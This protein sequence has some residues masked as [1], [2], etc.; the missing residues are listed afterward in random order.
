MGSYILNLTASPGD[1]YVFA[2]RR[3][4]TAVDGHRYLTT[5]VGVGGS[6]I[7]KVPK[8]PDTDI[9]FAYRFAEYADPSQKI[10]VHPR[11]VNGQNRVTVELNPYGVSIFGYKENIPQEMTEPYFSSP[12]VW[13]NVL[14]G[15]NCCGCGYA[16]RDCYWTRSTTYRL[17]SACTIRIGLP[18]SMKSPRVT[19]E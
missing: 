11:F 14:V 3:G 13:Y 1:G 7:D 6:V 12:D 8:F 18:D 10:R 15:A 17:P 19:T 9:E 5:A 16:A 4:A 2:G